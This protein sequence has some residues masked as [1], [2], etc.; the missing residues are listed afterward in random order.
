MV[1]PAVSTH[2][3]SFA[4]TSRPEKCFCSCTP[5]C[6]CGSATLLYEA[7]LEKRQAHTLSKD[8][9]ITSSFSQNVRLTLCECFWKSHLEWSK[10]SAFSISAYTLGHRNGL[11]LGAIPGEG[12]RRI[13]LTKC[14][15][16]CSPQESFVQ[17]KTLHSRQLKGSFRHAL[18]H[19]IDIVC[20]H[21]N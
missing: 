8:I 11:S 3:G 1:I 4:Q 17:W 9:R 2:P 12:G 5:L 21:S 10:S 13:S 16:T 7:I 14:A 20:M 19:G 15:S 18:L 6:L